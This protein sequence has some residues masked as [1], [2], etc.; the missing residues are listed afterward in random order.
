MSLVIVG[1]VIVLQL[2][3]TGNRSETVHFSV[4]AVSATETITAPIPLKP[5]AP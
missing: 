5:E 4:V 2:T 3:V 1:V